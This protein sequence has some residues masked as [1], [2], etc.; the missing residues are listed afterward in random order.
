MTFDVLVAD[1]SDL[2]WRVISR[3]IR[4]AAPH[5]STLRVRDGDQALRFLFQMGLLTREPNV[6][7]LVV[8]DADIPLAPAPLVLKRMRENASTRAVPVVMLSK[9]I[10]V[11][12]SDVVRDFETDAVFRQAADADAFEVELTKIVARLS[13]R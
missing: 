4:Q 6:P 5:A 3:A 9:S 12:R 13:Q 8:L 11:E 2:H 10:D 1:A 7:S